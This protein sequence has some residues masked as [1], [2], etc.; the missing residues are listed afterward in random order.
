ML[1]NR[2]YSIGTPSKKGYSW[3]RLLL[4]VL[5]T[6]I[7]GRLL[8]LQIIKGNYYWQRAERNR[9]QNFFI[10]A[11]RGRIFSRK[12]TNLVGNQPI[13]SLLLA[14]EGLDSKIKKQ[15]AGKISKLTGRSLK[16]INRGFDLKEKQ[17]F[18]VVEII[19]NLST[20]EI[21]KIE[22]SSH[23]L[24]N[25]F[26]QV[27]SRR[28]YPYGDNG[29][30]LFG[31]IGEVSREELSARRS[32]GFKLKDKI[33]K[34]GI[35]KSY[36]DYLRGSDGFKK[37]EVGV[38]GE[39]RKLITS[40]PPKIGNDII[41][42]IDWDL[43]EAAYRALGDRAGAVVA[44]EPDTGEIL[45]WLSKP[46]FN[47]E[48]FT[49][50]FSKARAEK[51]FHDPKHPLYDRNIQGEYAPGSLFKVVTALSALESGKADPNTEYTCRGSIRIGYDRKLYRCWKNTKHGRLDLK[52]AIA[53]SCNVY[54]YQL[55]METGVDIIR[56]M[57][58]RMGFSKKSQEIFDYEN[59]GL[60]PSASWKKKKFNRIWYPG[61]S[62]NMSVGQ[63]YVLVNPMQL[64][65]A[66]SAVAASGKVLKPRLVKMILSP[67]GEVIEKREPIVEKTLDIDKKNLAFLKKAM[68]SVT[69]YGTAQYL[70][71]NMDVA[72]KTGTAENPHGE[73]H[74]WYAGFA[75]VENPRIAV[76]VLVENGGYGSVASMPV[77]R[78]IYKAKFKEKLN[79][80]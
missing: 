39:H 69:E 19:S 30:H 8:Y 3:P 50:P 35:E 62:A 17:P 5:F 49:L 27:N 53:N 38:K 63:G 31:Y 59:T 61:D 68:R 65:K 57:A 44:M 72:S 22:E 32:G 54:F 52:D 64:L 24:P 7:A 1:F 51:I 25:V 6:V 15:L 73:D 21:M 56:D 11:P 2:Y 37:I 10:K 58:L 74:A 67:E 13:Y 28:K 66:F 43:Q 18:G 48:D 4:A 36:D 12:G 80:K 78:E 46:G 71:L 23:Y 70:N 34:T 47:P 41:L 14:T 60:I 26:I 77:A 55:G 45:V 33:G 42:T 76:V 9:I 75:P 16:E 40:R 29:A 79:E 20:E